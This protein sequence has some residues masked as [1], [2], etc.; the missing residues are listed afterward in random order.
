MATLI[1]TDYQLWAQVRG[2]MYRPCA[3]ESH[4]TCR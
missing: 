1:P 4:P 2:P 3:A